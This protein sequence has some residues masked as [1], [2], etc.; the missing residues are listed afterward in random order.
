M[1]GIA[2]QHSWRSPPP[3][4][5]PPHLSTHSP[6]RHLD[7]EKRS[8]TPCE[9]LGMAGDPHANN[10]CAP[11]SV[12]RAPLSTTHPFIQSGPGTAGSACCLG[13]AGMTR[14][15]STH[16]M[17]AQFLLEPSNRLR[18]TSILAPPPP[19]GNTPKLTVPSPPPPPSS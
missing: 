10:G 6:T 3:L 13:G 11:V 5:I 7:A 16:A 17:S 2:E 8:N 19:Q 9:H 18:V 15:G 4:D 1:M 14:G 12:L